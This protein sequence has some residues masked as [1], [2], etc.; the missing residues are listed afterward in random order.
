M[1]A[2][3]LERIGFDMF[4]DIVNY[5][6]QSDTNPFTRTAKLLDDNLNTIKDAHNILNK[7]ILYRLE[8]NYNLINQ[9]DINN[10]AIKKLN[11]PKQFELFQDIK[12]N[13][14]TAFQQGIIDDFY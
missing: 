2:N 3:S 5:D 6:S 13:I 9:T 4:T 10:I 8:C 12:Y 14:E 11:E 7:D 1:A